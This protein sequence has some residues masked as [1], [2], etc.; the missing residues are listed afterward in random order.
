[1]KNIKKFSLVLV[2]I[3]I[4]VVAV[5]GIKFVR[6]VT[7]GTTIGA[8]VNK[9][10]GGIRIII[11][12][13]GCKNNEFALSWWDTEMS[14]KNSSIGGFKSKD[15]RGAVL[16]AFRY[17][18]VDFTDFDFTGADLFGSMFV[19]SNFTNVKFVG[20]TLANDFSK[21]DFTRADLTDSIGN[22]TI[23]AGTLMRGANLTNANLAGSNFTNSDFTGAN[24]T[25]THLEGADLSRAIFA[26]ATGLETIHW[27]GTTTCPDGSH[28]WDHGDTCLNNLV[29]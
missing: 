28:G 5:C 20:T 14:Q 26:E 27:D 4:G 12:G 21:S 13:K 17:A 7:G 9:N 2:G 29:F 10:D 6:A 23:F 18:Y 24:L 8:C 3:V 22:A 19:N 25:G 16:N 11:D 15:F 1:M